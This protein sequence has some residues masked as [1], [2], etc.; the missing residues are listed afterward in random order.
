MPQESRRLLVKCPRLWDTWLADWHWQM[1]A[2]KGGGRHHYE[3]RE[4]KRIV[5]EIVDQ[6]IR[7][8]FVSHIWTASGGLGDA[9]SWGNYYSIKDTVENHHEWLQSIWYV[10]TDKVSHWRTSV[11]ELDKDRLQLKVFSCRLLLKRGNSSSSLQF[12]TQIRSTLLP[13]LE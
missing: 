8:G 2:F 3:H 12:W 1:C 7:I 6:H 10:A 5:L 9:G 11:A 4:R 13:Y